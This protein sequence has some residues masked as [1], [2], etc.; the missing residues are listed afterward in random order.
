MERQVF[1]YCERG[2]DPSFW[3]EPLNAVS[4]GAFLIAGLAALISIAALPPERRS[5]YAWTLALLILVIGVGSFL[6]HTFATRWAGAMDVFPIL[7]FMLLAVYTL[8]R[9]L[10]D[11]P[12]WAAWLTVGGFLALGPAMRLIPCSGPACGSL[13]YAPALLFLAVGGLLLARAGRAAG[14]HLALAAGVF[15][16]SLTLRSLDQPTCP[17]F[18]VGGDPIG[19]HFWW[20]L[21]NAATLYLVARGVWEQHA[22]GGPTRSSAAA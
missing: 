16:V 2:D 6:F 17:W 9:K 8:A 20:H 11:V 10:F 7:A 3:A 14:R 22:S 4:N 13:G 1:I 19:T 21:L 18:V 5:L 12:I 15:A